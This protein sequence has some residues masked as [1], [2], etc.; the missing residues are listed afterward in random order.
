M[1][2]FLNKNYFEVFGF[3]VEYTIDVASLRDRFVEVQKAVHPDK[4]SAEAA[5]LQRLAAQNAAHATQAFQTLKDPVARGFC[6]LSLLGFQCS[7]ESA[8]INDGAFLM[9]QMAF[10]ERLE[11]ADE[12]GLLALSTEI[13]KE[14]AALEGNVADLLA[15]PDAKSCLSQVE[16]ELKKMQFYRRLLEEIESKI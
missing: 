10:R 2:D 4:F 11:E 3:P 6:I 1:S 15:K 7:D 8:T 14:L 9:R 5:Q 12:A 16:S 13:E